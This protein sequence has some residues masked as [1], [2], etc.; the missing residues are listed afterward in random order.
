LNKSL[1][2]G[3]RAR[4]YFPAILASAQALVL[5]LQSTTHRRTFCTAAFA[6]P[7]SRPVCIEKENNKIPRIKTIK[8]G[9]DYHGPIHS[10]EIQEALVLN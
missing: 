4:P 6:F 7:A 3:F 2:I 8:T 9:W 5:D 10:A 1:D